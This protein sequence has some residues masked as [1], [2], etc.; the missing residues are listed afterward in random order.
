MPSKP[1]AI[2]VESDEVAEWNAAERAEMRVSR[3]RTT[4]AK[5][6][7]HQAGSE[8]LEKRR[9]QLAA[10]IKL[11]KERGYLTHTEIHDHLSDDIVDPDAIADILRTVDD[12]GVTV[13]DQAPDDAMLLLS[14]RVASGASDDEVEAVAATALLAD[15]GDYGRSTDPVRMYMREMSATDL[16]TREGEIEIAKRIED[17]Q[18]EMIGA[19]SASPAALG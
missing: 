19:I 4:T 1:S 7:G 3:S 2:T 14:D 8:V 10:L 9:K 18:Q 16:L 12:M 5:P 15:D 11:G 13:Y 6:A 17:G